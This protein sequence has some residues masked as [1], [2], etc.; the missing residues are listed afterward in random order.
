M[1]IKLTIH[2][3]FWYRRVENVQLVKYTLFSLVGIKNTLLQVSKSRA[4]LLL[5]EKKFISKGHHYGEL[6]ISVLYQD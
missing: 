2:L 6:A 3:F 1:V 4:K 5:C